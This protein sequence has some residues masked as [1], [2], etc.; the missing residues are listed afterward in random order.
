M[1]P[2]NPV[3][4][5]SSSGGSGYPAPPVVI[6]QHSESESPK[7]EEII[8]QKEKEIILNEE[9]VKNIPKTKIIPKIADISDISSEKEIIHQLIDTADIS[10]TEIK[11]QD[12]EI[13]LQA[14]ALSSG[15][16]IKPSIPLIIFLSI[17]GILLLVRKFIKSK[18]YE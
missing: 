18:N 2:N 5:Y 17:V 12:K 9:P 7:N 4:V 6:A 14:S 13:N 16:N 3:V 15:L 8:V 11:E 1:I 10:E